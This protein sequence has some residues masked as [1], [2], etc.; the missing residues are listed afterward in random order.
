MAIF[1]REPLLIGASNAGGVGQN[2][3]SQRISGFAIGTCCTVVSL[4]HIAA[5]FLLTAGFGLPN[6]TR[7]KQSRSSVTVYRVG[8]LKIP[9]RTKCNFLTTVWYFYIQ[10]SWF[11]WERCCCNSE[12]QKKYFS[13]LQ[14]YSYIDILCHIFNSARNTQQQLVIIIYVMVSV[15]VCFGGK[16]RLHLI[17]NKTKVN[18]ELYVKTLLPELVQDCRSV[19]SSGFIFQQDGAPAQCTHGKAGSRLD[20]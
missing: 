12:L 17:P 11:I 18:A 6:A 15:G 9:H 8:Q 4:W 19:L 3:D 14:S 2:L 7:Y 5:G 20:C 10:I 1:G 13:L 16:G